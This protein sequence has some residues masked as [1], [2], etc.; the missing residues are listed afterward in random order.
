MKHLD[1]GKFSRDQVMMTLSAI[2]YSPFHSIVALQDNLNS[3][4]ALEQAYSAIWW[5]KDGSIVVYAVKNKLTEDYVVIISGPVFKPGLP[6][7]FSLY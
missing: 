4:E 7:L 3:A 6:F 1:M 2:A 5:G